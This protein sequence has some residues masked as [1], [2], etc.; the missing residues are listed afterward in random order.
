MVGGIFMYCDIATERR[1]AMLEI[2][3]TAI[4]ITVICCLTQ[5]AM[6][7]MELSYMDRKNEKEGRYVN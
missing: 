7:A 3:G 1:K 6:K 5:I 2:C 4:L